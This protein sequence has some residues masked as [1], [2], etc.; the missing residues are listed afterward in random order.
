M[1]EIKR[2]EKFNEFIE[3]NEP[4]ILENPFIYYHLDQTIDR[5][6]KREVSVS[7]FFNVSSNDGWTC[8]LLVKNQCLIYSTNTNPEIIPLISEELDFQTFEK[9]P[10][11]G[12]KNTIESLL[13]YNNSE[14]SDIKHRNYYECTEVNK[15]LDY[16]DGEAVSG[17]LSQFNELVELQ[18]M[19]NEEFYS[20]ENRP[21]DVP[22]LV[23]QGIEKDNIYQWLIND[24]VVG[25]AQIN[26]H[27]FDFPII[28]F[29]FISPNYRNMKIGQSFVHILTK[30]LFDAG[31][32]KCCLMTEASNPAS[33]KSFLNIGYKLKEEYVIRLKE[34]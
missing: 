31:H 28:G 10:F 33:N 26:Y 5:V 27:E 9:F 1:S 6:C 8:I 20:A 21:K 29:V 22:S 25:M 16:S 3:F 13:N 30:G 34:K 32:K 2:F 23:L 17:T 14:F 12:S 4:V 7:K 18:T 11:F 19:F 15:L 24:K